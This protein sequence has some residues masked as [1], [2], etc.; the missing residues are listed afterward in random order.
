VVGKR[1][2]AQ[3]G[4]SRA[5]TQLRVVVN[6]EGCGDDGGGSEQMPWV[7]PHSP[8]RRLEPSRGALDQSA[9]TL[10]KGMVIRVRGGG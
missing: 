1:A 2:E 5:E 4:V 7:R 6:D 3:S 8:W 10:K 9:L